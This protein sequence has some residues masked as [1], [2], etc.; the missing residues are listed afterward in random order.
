MIVAYDLRTGTPRWS[1]STPTRH[2]SPLSGDGPCA[3]P[4]IAGTSIFAVGATGRLTALELASG[5]EIWSREILADVGAGKPEYGLCSSPLVIDDHVSATSA[6]AASDGATP[7]G[8]LTGLPSINRTVIVV[9]GGRGALRAYDAATGTPRWSDGEYKAAYTSPAM[10]TLAGAPQIVVFHGG[11]PDGDI[12][13]H[14][15]DG[16]P[17]WHRP[18]PRVQRT[19]Q[20]VLLPDDRLL[21]SSG[22]GAGAEVFVVR[23]QGGTFTTETVWASKAIKAKFTQ[24]VHRN[25]YLYGLD[26]G[27]LVAVDAATGDRAWKRGRYGHGQILLFDETILV[28]SEKGE[29]A[30]VDA[31]PDAYREVARIPAINGRTWN[32]PAFANPY[33]IVRNPQEAAAFKLPI[34]EN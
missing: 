3:T 15:L 27:I 8:T 34:R 13:G 21:I 30:V 5:P 24:V 31:S 14:A 11:G 32:T 26:D 6:D 16:R 18:W 9:T 19:S 7:D 20:P 2:Q 12:T 4:T 28:L 23:E 33:L 17:L 22:Y 10:I 29:I 25:G 1:H